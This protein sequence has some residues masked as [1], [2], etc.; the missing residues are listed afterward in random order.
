MSGVDASRH[1]VPI[2]RLR[3]STDPA[4]LGFRDTDEMGCLKGL[5]GQER[6]VRSISFGLSVNSKGYNLFVV[7]NP[8][9]GR[10]TYV[11]EELNNRAKEMPAPDDWVYVYNFK[12]PQEPVAISLP[13]GVGR[14]LARDME[15]LLEDLKVTLSKA[16]DNSQYEDNK[17]Q[18]VKEVQEQVNHVMEELRAWAGEKGLDMGAPKVQKTEWQPG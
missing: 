3:R 15:E 9:S 10:T 18:L 14:E 13:A 8:G 16:F 1:L 11:L 7:G 2:D 5:I 6:A 17:A 12:N 4:A